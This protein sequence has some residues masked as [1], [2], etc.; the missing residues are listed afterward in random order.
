MCSASGAP[1]EKSILFF[2]G[3]FLSSKKWN[4]FLR[5]V[6]A[7]NSTTGCVVP[8]E[9]RQKNLFYFLEDAFYPRKNGMIFFEELRHATQ[10]QGCES[11]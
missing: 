3:C 2:R 4:D 5:G 1:T 8:R 7:R 11:R 9:L 10:L 6:E